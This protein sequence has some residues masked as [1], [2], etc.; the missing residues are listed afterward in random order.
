MKSRVGLMERTNKHKIRAHTTDDDHWF[1][2][3]DAPRNTTLNVVAQSIV[4]TVLFQSL[5][6]YFQFVSFNLEWPKK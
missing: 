5:V 1:S 2:S 4:D 6:F 3:V